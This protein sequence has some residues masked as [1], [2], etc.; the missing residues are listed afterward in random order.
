MYKEIDGANL[1]ERQTILQKMIEEN[2][3]EKDVIDWLVSG[4][5][6][7]DI[8]NYL[9]EYKLVNSDWLWKNMEKYVEQDEMFENWVDNMLEDRMEA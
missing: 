5:D 6:A 2:G 9:V 1:L 3:L 4:F 7:S 8:A